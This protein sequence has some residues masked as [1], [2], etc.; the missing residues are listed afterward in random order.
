MG[1]LSLEELDLRRRDRK[2]ISTTAL[3]SHIEAAY[4]PLDL[5]DERWEC[6]L[7]V[8]E[9]TFATAERPGRRL[10]NFRECFSVCIRY[11]A[12]ERCIELE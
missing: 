4:I 3:K 8:C 12:A 1:R 7:F 11:S 6:D 10:L 9:V 5:A 2:R